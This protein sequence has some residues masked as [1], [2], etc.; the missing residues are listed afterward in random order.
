MTRQ[1]NK[2]KRWT[3]EE[4]NV[5]IE[6]VNQCPGNNAKAFRMCEE[7]LERR[8]FRACQ[9]RWYKVLNKNQHVNNMAI[10]GNHAIATRRVVREGCPVEPVK[11]KRGW[12]SKIHAFLFG[13]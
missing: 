13:E 5:L 8:D 12:W 3:Q 7:K 9:N 1:D 4:D 11:L 2:Y 6:C 10:S